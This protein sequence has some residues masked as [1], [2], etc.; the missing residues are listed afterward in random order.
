[1]ELLQHILPQST[2]HT[3]VFSQVSFSGTRLL[4][5]GRSEKIGSKQNGGNLWG[6]IQ[7]GVRTESLNPSSDNDN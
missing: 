4:T 6:W 2:E 3:D 5:R 7:T 1:M